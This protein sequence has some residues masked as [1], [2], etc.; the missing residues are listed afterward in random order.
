MGV[1]VTDTV[2]YECMGNVRHKHPR[3]ICL[4]L[5]RTKVT[6]KNI[7]IVAF[8]S[9]LK[10]TREIRQHYGRMITNTTSREVRLSSNDMFDI[11]LLLIV[12]C[13]I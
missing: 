6:N 10:Y 13:Y 12:V 4:C 7:Q 11:V 5:A 2:T 9:V 8:N 3:R 1:N